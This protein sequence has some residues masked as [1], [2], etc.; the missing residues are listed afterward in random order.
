LIAAEI[1]SRLPA[2]GISLA[3]TSAGSLEAEVPNP[4]T[5]AVEEALSLVRAHRAEVLAALRSTR[6]LAPLAPVVPFDPVARIRQALGPDGRG[7]VAVRSRVLGEI[8]LWTR[9]AGTEV[10][11]HV[12]GLVRFTWAELDILADGDAEALRE[13]F[14]AKKALDGTVTAFRRTTP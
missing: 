14:R 13:A 8:V 4:A 2:L 7:W 1:L 3:V 5:P 12:A 10:P 11:A 9:N 6:P